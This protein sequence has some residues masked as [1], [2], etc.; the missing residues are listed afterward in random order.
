MTRSPESDGLRGQCSNRL[1]FIS[2][3]C[4]CVRQVTTRS[5]VDSLTRT[6][7]DKAACVCFLPSSC[8]QGHT[9]FRHVRSTRFP[10]HYFH[11]AAA[12]LQAILMRPDGLSRPRS[13]LGCDL[14][15]V[16]THPL[17]RALFFTVFQFVDAHAHELSW[18][19]GTCAGKQGETQ[20]SIT[21]TQRGPVRSPQSDHR[22]KQISLPGL[23]K[24]VLFGLQIT[25][26]IVTFTG[27]GVTEKWVPK[28]YPVFGTASTTRHL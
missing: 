20:S 24:F 21:H 2:G 14:M 28:W 18:F 12:M 10:V 4:H 9:S 13:A 3:T 1:P 17:T 26:Q 6:T 11:V 25:L 8:L 22:G 19:T 23:Q 27:P 16:A 7:Q 5:W 15:C